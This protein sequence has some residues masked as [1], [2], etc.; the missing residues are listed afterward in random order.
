MSSWWSPLA[1]ATTPPGAGRP[2][3]ETTPRPDSADPVQLAR[4]PPWPHTAAELT[5]RGTRPDARPRPSDRS[6][7]TPRDDPRRRAPDRH[8]SVARPARPTR[9]RRADPDRA[10]QASQTPPAGCRTP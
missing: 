5:T 8:G 1:T 6:R 7:R 4:R 3:H 9:R 10:G 2:Y